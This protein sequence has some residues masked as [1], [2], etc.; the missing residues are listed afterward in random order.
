MGGAP[1]LWRTTP[2]GRG[3]RQE[4]RWGFATQRR[5]PTRR[6]ERNG[7]RGIV[8]AARPRSAETGQ[9]VALNTP[10]IRPQLTRTAQRTPADRPL[11][12][13]PRPWG[14]TPHNQRTV[15]PPESVRC[16]TPEYKHN[17]KRPTTAVPL[18][19]PKTVS[20]QRKMPRAQAQGVRRVYAGCMPGV[21]RVYTGCIPGVFRVHAGYAPLEKGHQSRFPGPVPCPRSWL[22][23]PWCSPPVPRA[24][25]GIAWP[26]RCTH[27]PY[28]MRF[29]SAR[30]PW[31]WSGI[32]WYWSLF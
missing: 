12:A 1:G 11:A 14:P 16:R 21:C 3:D 6:L 17:S 4:T 7:E 26:Q 28:T 15:L 32:G 13:A 9:D 5:C 8:R 22:A 24:K 20:R 10:K 2:D 30:C 27:T 31:Y 29:W 18:S 19:T 23:L 25:W